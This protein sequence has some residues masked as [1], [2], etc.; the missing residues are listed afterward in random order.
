MRNVAFSFRV[1]QPP[2]LRGINITREIY[3]S[4][5][6]ICCSEVMVS[7]P[8]CG[9]AG[10]HL[11]S[12]VHTRAPTHTN[13]RTHRGLLYAAHYLSTTS[14]AGTRRKEVLFVQEDK[15]TSAPSPVPSRLEQHNNEQ[16]LWWK[17]RRKHGK[18]IE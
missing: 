3:S 8:V 15:Y 18:R 6:C 16:E 7:V 17:V 5:V 4:F 9:P 12:P 1:K 13:A 10:T 2:E 14:R 11:S